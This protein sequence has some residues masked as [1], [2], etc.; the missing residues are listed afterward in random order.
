MRYLRTILLG[1]LAFGT[2]CHISPKI[3]EP[4]EIVEQQIDPIYFS[5]FLSGQGDR[6]LSTLRS[7]LLNYQSDEEL[8]VR[9]SDDL[10]RSYFPIL[11]GGKLQRVRIS[12]DIIE[13]TNSGEIEQDVPGYQDQLVIR[14]TSAL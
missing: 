7:R 4:T 14:S 5:N 12:K 13:L 10:G 2:T 3:P 8:S 9:S 11:G 1:A 6:F